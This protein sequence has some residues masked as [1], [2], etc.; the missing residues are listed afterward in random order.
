MDLTREAID[1]LIDL[2]QPQ[3]I[4]LADMKYVTRP[5]HR[6]NDPVAEPLKGWSLTSVIDY[7]AKNPDK[8][9]DCLVEVSSRHVCVTSPLNDDRRR[10][11]YFVSEPKVP[12]ITFNDFIDVEKMKI[13]IMSQFVQDD[14][15]AILLSFLGQLCEQSGTELRDNGVSQDI[16]VNTGIMNIE[17]VKVPNPITLRPYRTF[18]DIEQPASTFVFR[19]AKGLRCALFEADGGAWVETEVEG[20]KDFLNVSFGSISGIKICLLG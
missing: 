2:G 16:A 5:V 4:K 19:M 14:Q 18:Y 9:A 13:T 8:I 7:L 6:V 17:D 12:R 11:V 20:I 10:D 1:R 15:T 3:P